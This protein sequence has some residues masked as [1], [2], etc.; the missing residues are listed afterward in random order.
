VIRFARARAATRSCSA[1]RLGG[2]ATLALDAD[3][4]RLALASDSAER[5]KLAASA[6]RRYGNSR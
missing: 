6:L 2:V 3:E 5:S 1:K 4:A